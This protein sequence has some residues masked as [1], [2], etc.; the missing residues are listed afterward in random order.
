MLKAQF[1]GSAIITIGTFVVAFALMWIIRQLPYPWNLRVEAKG[2]TGTGGIDVFEHG[3]EA[4]PNERA[5]ADMPEYHP[6]PKEQ[7]VLS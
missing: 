7:P 3:T 2:E 4:Y 1:I 5:A 6:Q